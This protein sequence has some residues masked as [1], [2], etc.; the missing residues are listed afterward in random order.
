M[1]VIY[2]VFFYFHD[3]SYPYPLNIEYNIIDAHMQ[4]FMP[5]IF[6]ISHNTHTYGCGYKTAKKCSAINV[7]WVNGQWKI[8]L[9]K[10]HDKF[11]HDNVKLLIV[12][13]KKYTIFVYW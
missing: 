6:I 4:P 3:I 2:F 8:S 7:K 5:Q 13:L 9:S 1:P 10:K 12:L 11:Q